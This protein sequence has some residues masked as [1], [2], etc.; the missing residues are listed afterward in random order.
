MVYGE[1]DGKSIFRV[2]GRGSS[3]MSISHLVGLAE[4]VIGDALNQNFGIREIHISR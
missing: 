2:L 4:R 3:Q 1:I